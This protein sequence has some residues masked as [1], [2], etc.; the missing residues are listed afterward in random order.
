MRL[1]ALLI[2]LFLFTSCS[3]SKYYN[4]V[5]R[6]KGSDTM[7]PITELLA[8]EF[9]KQN[10]GVSIYTEGGGSGRGAKSLAIGQCEICAASRALK[11][12]EIKE[13]AENYQSVGVAHTIAKDALS[14]YLNSDNPIKNINLDQLK[15]IFTGKILN[16]REIGGDDAP[17]KLIIRPPSSGTHYYFRQRILEGEDYSNISLTVA[18]TDGVIDE[19]IDD[20]YAIG[21][22]GIGYHENITLA[23]IN[24][25]APTEDNVIKDKYPII[26]YLYFYTPVTSTGPVKDFIDW[27]ISSP[28]Q[29]IVKKSGYFPLWKVSF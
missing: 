1:S 24:G 11:P 16:W 12:E 9:M 19:V 14:V 25:V 17:I 15:N 8:E 27:V 23:N 22:G 5:I 29:N 18:T 3:S 6:I 26:R 13:I 28:G 21:Y 10:K 7:L 2:I 20:K 4:A